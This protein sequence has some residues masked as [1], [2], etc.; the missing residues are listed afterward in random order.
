MK[1]SNKRIHLNWSRLVGFNQVPAQQ[2]TQATKRAKAI[3]AAKI[4]AK[5]VGGGGG[6]GGIIING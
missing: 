2:D 4:G 5:P 3:V 6:G 1:T